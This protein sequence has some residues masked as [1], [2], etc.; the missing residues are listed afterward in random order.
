[1]ETLIGR[2]KSTRLDGTVVILDPGHGGK[3]P[4]AIVTAEDGTEVFEKT[5]NLEIAQKL[6]PN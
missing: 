3:D 5:L 6:K 1:M 4:G 2:E